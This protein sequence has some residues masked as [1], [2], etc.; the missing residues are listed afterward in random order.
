MKI[1]RGYLRR[2]IVA[3][4]SLITVFIATYTVY[5]LHNK[6]TE[7]FIYIYVLSGVVLLPL[8]IFDFIKFY[9]QHKALLLK[10]TE[11]LP[12]YSLIEEDLKEVI[13]DLE[14]EKQSL[15]SKDRARLKELVDYYSLWIHQ[16]KT[17][18]SALN[19][20][21]QSSD[22]ISREDFKKELNSIEYYTDMAL[23]FVRLEN[24]NNDLNF[25]KVN[26]DPILRKSL[27]KF[28]Q[29]FIYKKISLDYEN[30]NINIISDLKWLGFAI[31]QII[32]NA[33]KYSSNSTIKIYSKDK[34]LF[35]EDKGI[36]ISS[37][38]LPRVFEKGF[39]GN[40]G[41]EEKKSS[42]IGLYM[43]KKILDTLSHK[44]EIKSKLGYG[45]QVI[46]DLE[47]DDFSLI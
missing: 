44:I 22:E 47:S 8:F 15:I 28:T 36:G 10:N 18:I 16:I 7:P 27:K 3:I 33:L 13:A 43:A 39:T 30:T 11:K 45:T 23:G 20:V 21:L 4:I 12:T 37:E 34:K 38:D 42:G 6:D 24:I 46:I 32:S 26:L 2:N 41:R 14:N 9:K 35:I 5:F 1:L 17:P 19:L 29:I 31:E 40:N 25:S